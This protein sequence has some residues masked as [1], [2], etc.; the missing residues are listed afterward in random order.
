[1]QECKICKQF[2]LV[3]KNH[4]IKISLKR[5]MKKHHNNKG[6]SQIKKVGSR[7]KKIQFILKKNT[8]FL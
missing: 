2:A 4:S 8:S 6:T 5:K 1:M 7:I 3:L